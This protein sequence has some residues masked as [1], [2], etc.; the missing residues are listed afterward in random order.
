[1]VHEIVEISEYEAN[2][3]RMR[4]QRAKEWLEIR[5]NQQQSEKELVQKSA[6]VHDITTDCGNSK[7]I[8][9][10]DNGMSCVMEGTA[11]AI[12][13]IHETE[14]QTIDGATEVRKIHNMWQKK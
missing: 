4:E 8:I 12:P 1:M 9:T 3:L 5:K 10:P 6:A 2:N 14:E 11:K 7:N 13:I